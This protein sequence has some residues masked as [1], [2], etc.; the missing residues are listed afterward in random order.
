MNF[1][2]ASLETVLSY[3]SEAAGF[4][5]NVRP[6]TSV[7]GKV[8]VW[9][10][11]TLTKEEALELL[12]TVLNQNSLAAIRNGKVL[13]IVNRDEAK[14]Q[15]VP[16]IQEAD[17]AKIPSTDRIVTQIIPVRF[18][19]VAQ[20]VKDLQPL[21]S[22]QTTITAN[23]A[24]NSLVITDTQANIKKVAEVVRA[25]DMGAEDVGLVKVFH[26]QHAD[27]NETADL[28]TNLFP[29]DSRTGGSQGSQFGGRFG[30]FG[31]FFGR[32]GGGAGG[33]GGGG[34]GNQ[35][36]TGNNQN[37]RLRKRNRV[38]AV[39]DPRTAS[40]VV[41]ASRDLMAQI[42]G[43]IEDLDSDAANQQGIAI[44]H[45]QNAQPQEALQ[46][47][48]DIFNKNN[49]QN[50]RN[51]TANQTS[52]LTGRSTAQNQQNNNNSSRTSTMNGNSRGIGAGSS[53]G[54]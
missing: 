11:D 25:I 41:T 44:F 46:V 45:M 54:Q 13:S 4:I 30:G 8:D 12:D 50:N 35:G 27:P 19:E 22:V 18:V 39:A 31:G 24:G 21:L 47:F 28:L 43:V 6:G 5:I 29:D 36:G 38:V 53:F 37:Q 40:V 15:N 49:Q 10:N 2:G 34:G 16:V 48:Q 52:P 7:R 42:E 32:G 33:F 9:S 14:T 51:N 23:E 26:L 1:R 20:L 17:P 3:L